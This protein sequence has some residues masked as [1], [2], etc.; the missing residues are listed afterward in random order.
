VDDRHLRAPVLRRQRHLFAQLA[1]L[2][3]HDLAA[4]PRRLDLVVDRVTDQQQ[5][6]VGRM[7]PR[8]G[9]AAVRAYLDRLGLGPGVEQATTAALAARFAATRRSGTQHA[10]RQPF[11][12][13]A[14]AQPG[15]PTQQKAMAEPAASQ[16][17]D[18]AVVYALLPR[19]QGPHASLPR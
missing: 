2:V 16:R 17:R 15:R 14:L 13:L 7:A 18:R 11:G 10:A 3:D 6:R 12:D 1:Y 9:Q 8:V 5:V 4:R 19:G